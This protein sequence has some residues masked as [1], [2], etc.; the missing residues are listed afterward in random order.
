MK[1]GTIYQEEE[2]IEELRQE[3]AR[4]AQEEYERFIHDKSRLDAK[5]L[6]IEAYEG[7]LYDRRRLERGLLNEKR[8]KEFEKNRPP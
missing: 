4:P 6:I 2:R 1:K 8:F 7:V 3:L 5:G